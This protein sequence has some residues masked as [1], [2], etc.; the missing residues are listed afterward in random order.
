[1]D[2]VWFEPGLTRSDL[3]RFTD[4]LALRGGQ[5]VMFAIAGAEPRLVLA[6]RALF[7]LFDVATDAALSARLL[8]GRD[9]G[10][11]RLN[12]LVRT[13]PLEGAPRLERLRF[14]IGAGSEVITVLCRRIY[15]ANGAPILVAAALG[16]RSG[17]TRV[18]PRPQP[19]EDASR[20]AAVPEPA[21]DPNAMGVQAIQ[22]L[23]HTRWPASRTTRFLWQ[24]DADGVCTAIT[25]PLAAVVGPVN[26][27][28]I[29]RRMLDIAPV[30]DP[31]GTLAAALER[32][33]TWSGLGVAWPVSDASAAIAVG[34]GAIPTFD[35]DK[36]FGGYRGYG[37]I[38]L[39]RV[40]TCPPTRIPDRA[41]AVAP[42]NV[43]AFPGGKALSPEDKLAFVALGA[44]LRDQAGLVETDAPAHTAQA[45]PDAAE[46]VLEEAAPGEGNSGQDASGEAVLHAATQSGTPAIVASQQ[47]E[48]T[49]RV[50]ELP[51]QVEPVDRELAAEVIEAAAPMPLEEAAAH[52]ATA[53]EV[54]LSQAAAD[55]GA[56]APDAMLATLADARP[57][58][59]V[60]ADDVSSD[61]VGRNGL[62]ILD[63][64]LIGLLVSRD[65]IP[66]FVNRH[67]L[68]TL[69]FADEDA[70][71][72]AGGMGHLFG[73][74]PGNVTGSEAIGVRDR[75]GLVVPA[76]ARMQSIEWDGLPAT[77]LTLQ[78]ATPQQVAGPQM[79][80]VAS[81][82]EDDLDVAR[83]VTAQAHIEDT[84]TRHEERLARYEVLRFE[85][86]A[87][88]SHDEDEL[89]ELR[90][91]LETS[92]DGVVVIDAHGDVVSLN[93][94]GEALFGCERGTAAGRPFT[95]LFAPHDQP[96]AQSYFEELRSNARKSLLNDGCEFVV[97]AHQGTIPVFMT[98]GRL[99]PATDPQAARFCALFRDLTHWKKVERE[100]E[101]AR[102]DVE[103]ANALKTDF[104]SK[105]SREVR[106][107]LNTI[108]GLADA[109]AEE[110]FGPLG[111][112]RYKD[113][114]REIHAASRHVVGLVDDLLDLSKIEAGQMDLAA[115]ALDANRI[116]SDC[117]ATMQAEASRARIIMRLSLAPT[118]P[119][120]RADGRSLRQIVLNLLSNAV[121]FNEPGGQVIV[122]TTA[123]EGGQVLIRIRDTGSGMSEA[124]IK[125]ALEPFGQPA[126]GESA[127]GPSPGGQSPDAEPA[128]GSGLGLP[129]TKA[130]VEANGAT[131]TIRSKVDQ[132]TLV[133]VAF[134][135]ARVSA[136]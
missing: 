108:V 41:D 133:E 81:A 130:L 5:S 126:V 10:A 27:D 68:D 76:T 26:A 40:V 42:R 115:E 103:R 23:L 124:A 39:D 88:R 93:R 113:Y 123:T 13:L 107:P 36:V 85:V 94:A 86:E 67:L 83:I 131:I 49:E 25:P 31:S 50:N 92:A 62:A 57:A 18:P 80:R 132:G 100:L 47:V 30:L 61:G 32:R 110:R 59:A 90:A 70:L 33:E 45:V 125:A 119:Q 51:P 4:A 72:A 3:D 69:G 77:L 95:A 75:D 87:A 44:E 129:L 118:L 96:L 74:L 89:R 112:R 17:P 66:I 37:V 116:V 20:N 91:I 7:R 8:T 63:R 127:D 21:P 71:H 14:T 46:P 97:E 82:A 16:L 65:N 79:A 64:L 134:P 58:E 19:A 135:R 78:Q 117:V 104:L 28:L 128:T 35:G 15:E 52:Q 38:H 120:I 101:G 53:S 121:R 12:A 43:V 11:A 84:Q 56:V 24:T 48:P 98:L 111:D 55:D 105:V 2:D 54:T 60:R 9:G 102:R 99:G 34:L 29:G 114:L 73:D 122:A 106:G 22:A 109:V 6:G 136:G 1:M